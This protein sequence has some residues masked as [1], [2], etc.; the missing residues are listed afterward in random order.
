MWC[1]DTIGV[2][3]EK[4]NLSFFPFNT[5]VDNRIFF[6]NVIRPL[7]G[8]NFVKIKQRAK[9]CNWKLLNVSYASQINVNVYYVRIHIIG[10]WDFSYFLKENLS[11][12]QKRIIR[13]KQD[14]YQY[15]E[16]AEVWG[17]RRLYLIKEIHFFKIQGISLQSG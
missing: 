8:K 5:F 10:W 11:R 13:G 9:F 1:I 12:R 6:K 7:C 3:Y 14:L 17:I 15:Q 4:W 2:K 16:S